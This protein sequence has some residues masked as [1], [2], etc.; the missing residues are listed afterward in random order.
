[1]S[2]RACRWIR[3]GHQMTELRGFFL[4]LH[5]FPGTIRSTVRHKPVAEHRARLV[6]GG[7]QPTLPLSL[8]LNVSMGPASEH[9]YSNPIASFE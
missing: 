6:V 4:S 7:P 2:T 3:R 8:L 5:L 1:M 9:T